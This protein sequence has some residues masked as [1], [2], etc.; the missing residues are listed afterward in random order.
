MIDDVILMMIAT[1]YA[2]KYCCT[3]MLT[4]V[5]GNDCDDGGDDDDDDSEGGDEKTVK[6][7]WLLLLFCRTKYFFCTR[8]LI[9]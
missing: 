7:V 5:C 2:H 6:P 8:L 1:R 4:V 3:G 9:V